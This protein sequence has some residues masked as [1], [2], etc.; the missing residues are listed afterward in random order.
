MHLKELSVEFI[1]I[2]LCYFGVATALSEEI[3][4]TVV[5][6]PEDHD[7]LSQ[8]ALEMVF[9]S[10]NAIDRASE[11]PL[12]IELYDGGFFSL[13]K[14]VGWQIY[15]AG[16]CATFAFLVRDKENPLIQAFYFGEVGPFYI[17]QDNKQLEMNYVDAGGFP[18]DWV[19]MPVV[20]PLT[21][22][23]FLIHWSEIARTNVGQSF[24]PQRPLLDNLLIISAEPTYSTFT[25][26]GS[27][28]KLIRAIFVENE[29]L[30][31]GLFLVTTLVVP[32]G[33]YG[34]A[35]GV[36]GITAPKNEFAAYEGTLAKIVQSLTIS[37]DYAR[38]CTWNYGTG[39][40]LDDT[41]D[42]IITGWEQRNKVDDII[43][44]K[45]SDAIL[46][47]D[48]VYNPDTGTVYE[49]ELDFYDRY[50]IN[51]DAFEMNNLQ[52]LPDNSW[53]LWTSPAESGV[54]IR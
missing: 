6:A 44:Q 39:R 32:P 41:S 23:N 14:P 48:R 31:E 46:G 33:Y 3:N 13:L 25:F 52:P 50:N 26:S 24:M 5:Q 8:L 34:G 9:G 38:D 11:N 29:M 17:S 7:Y 1:I 19:D 21:P 42:I 36:I 18:I 51:R 37:P 45:G 10:D 53:G 16:S 22:E 12:E 2:V 40:I 20:D 49:V 28:T 35:V 47:I 27:Q 30:G 43:S 54:N 15:T 4:V